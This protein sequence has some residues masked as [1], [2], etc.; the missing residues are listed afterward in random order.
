MTLFCR[1]GNLARFTSI[2][3]RQARRTGPA[4]SCA[5]L[6]SAIPC[7]EQQSRQPRD[8]RVFRSF[9]RCFYSSQELP[10]GVRNSDRTQRSEILARTIT[11]GCSIGPKHNVST[12]TRHS[13]GAASTTLLKRSRSSS[14]GGSAKGQ[15]SKSNI[16]ATALRHGENHQIR[17]ISRTAGPEGPM[18]SA[19]HKGT[20]VHREQSHATH[21]S[22]GV[23]KIMRHVPHPV[24]IVT[25]TDVSIS[26]EGAP[27]AWRG[28]TVSSFNT[29]TLRPTPIVSFNITKRSST[30]EA[31]K[32]SGHFNVH[33]L[34]CSSGTS[35]IARR[36]S[37]GNASSP[38]H[39]EDGS[40]ASFAVKQH[41]NAPAPS[42]LGPQIGRKSPIIKTTPQ[43]VLRCNNI[44][45]K[46]VEIGDHVVVFGEVAEKVDELHQIEE[47]SVLLY[48]VN[49]KYSP[50][51]AEIKSGN[52]SIGR[53]L[54]PSQ[55]Q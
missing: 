23:R 11:T 44:A 41:M 51:I 43:A 28:A 30:Y 53:G 32:S 10:H 27:V 33:L 46:T 36:F 40:L 47:A 48:Y 20:T 22:D 34:P 39:D 21:L 7:L 24:A 15:G 2:G 45:H 55:N 13:S 17:M 38:F 8:P 12:D 37:R 14:W 1:P 31:I 3:P 19:S 42:H 50:L 54:L 4:S 52:V 6:G 25:S 18:I 29:V 5:D 26:P 16:G 9:G 35:S 49:G